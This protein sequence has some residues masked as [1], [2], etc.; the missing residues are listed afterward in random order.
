MPLRD[1]MLIFDTDLVRVQ[2]K[3]EFCS[4]SFQMKDMGE[5]DVIS[6]IK[7]IR[8]GNGIKLSR[9]HY[10][11]K[12]LKRFNMFNTAPISTP[13]D[14]HVKLC[15]HDKEPVSQLAYSKVIRSLMYAINMLSYVDLI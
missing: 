7:I 14:Q 1:D 6:G 12:V 11:E 3:K 2:E 5:A 4:S 15:R 8:D 13:M 10:I 9:A